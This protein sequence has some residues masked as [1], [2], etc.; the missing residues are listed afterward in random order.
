M[1]T[2]INT[3]YTCEFVLK[4]QY[5]NDKS[6]LENKIDD[7]CIKISHATGLLFQ[8]NDNTKITEKVKCLAS[9][10]YHLQKIFE[11]II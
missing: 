8:K 10:T 6:S 1:F 3:T 4:T 11:L 9:L 7:A 2:K 5:S